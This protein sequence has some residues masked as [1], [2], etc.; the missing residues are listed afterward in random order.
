MPAVMPAAPSVT[1]R[2]VF[3]AQKE[4]C[5]REGG[6]VYIVRFKAKGS[7]CEYKVLE[8]RPFYLEA[9]DM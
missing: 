8:D 2:R 1:G 9:D 3:L 4:T 5:K 7:N 6:R